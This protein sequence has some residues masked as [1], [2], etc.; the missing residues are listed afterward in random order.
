ML[1]RSSPIF[2]E[3]FRVW[4]PFETTPTCSTLPQLY[5]ILTH[6]FDAANCIKKLKYLSAS[7][8]ISIIINL[9]Y[10]LTKSS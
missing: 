2:L 9:Y 7:I 5:N 1:F 6:F 4:D 3:I 10:A 8:N